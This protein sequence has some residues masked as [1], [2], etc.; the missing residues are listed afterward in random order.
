M[1][2]RIIIFIFLVAS[3]HTFAE[4]K[5]LKHAVE[6]I[7]QIQGQDKST[8][9]EQN[10]QNKK[11]CTYDEYCD[12]LRNNKNKE[13]L[14]ESKDGKFIPNS[15]IM[16]SLRYKKGIDKT[17]EV[18]KKYEGDESKKADAETRKSEALEE[19]LFKVYN[20]IR[21]NK[22]AQKT[23]SCMETEMVTSIQQIKDSLKDSTWE[24]YRESFYPTA[25]SLEI[26]AH[27]NPE[28]PSWY[29]FDGKQLET[30]YWQLYNK[31]KGWLA[32]KKQKELFQSYLK[33]YVANYEGILEDIKDNDKYTSKLV[34][35][36]RPWA[37][38]S[39][40]EQ[41]TVETRMTEIEALFE[42]AKQ[43]ILKHLD[44]FKVAGNAS[45]IE[46]AKKRLSQV[47]LAK[48]F[49]K[50]YLSTCSEG[51]N[52]YYS[53]YGQAITMCP[54]FIEYPDDIIA[55]I[56]AH[57]LGHS[58]DPCILASPISFRRDG[59]C[60]TPGSAGRLWS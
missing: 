40:K 50:D 25:A 13:K 5:K 57:E 11:P 9:Y 43:S 17:N 3:L 12:F 34:F 36:G 20:S 49:P 18:I 39:E 19:N 56:F 52:A 59:H 47:I 41:K 60:R 54:Q 53:P 24:R 45:G 28:E 16:D 27:K 30:R 37:S 10:D 29:T 55:S 48:P 33:A 22:T 38:L 46:S 14:Y 15:S 8:C 32:D 42:D 6:K 26:L 21:T 44:T 51:I 7:S 1:A 35:A 2:K 23:L 31:C 58:I 4:A